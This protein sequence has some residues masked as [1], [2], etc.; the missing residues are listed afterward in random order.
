MKKS[1][2]WLMSLLF[3]VSLVVTSC[4]ESDGVIDPYQNWTT[5][6]R[7]FIDSIANV[8]KSNPSEWKIIHT[9]KYPPQSLL[10]GDADEY[11]YCKVIDNGNG[12]TPLFTDTVSVNYRGTLIPLLDGSTVVFDQSY[13][14]IL[15]PET[16]VPVSFP[17]G[18]VID[19]WASALQDMK[20][21]D[22]WMVYIPSELGYGEMK[23]NDI[24]ANSTLIFDIHLV[25][26]KKLK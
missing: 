9:Y 1:I 25:K 20:A 18:G 15:E 10:G 11:V 24:P 14:G 17:L 23:H 21:G 7:Q 5:R 12:E 16:A 26:V 4:D 19:G 2:F 3:T 6:N 22:R 13:S 8:A